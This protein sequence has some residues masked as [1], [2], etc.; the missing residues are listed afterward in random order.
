M[1]VFV[2]GAID[3]HDSA[4]PALPSYVSGRPIR[5]TLVPILNMPSVV[6][7]PASPGPG[8]LARVAAA[9]VALLQS[10]ERSSLRARSRLQHVRDLLQSQ[11]ERIEAVVS[12]GDEVG[13]GA[14]SR[15]FVGDMP[16]YNVGQV[17]VKV[18]KVSKAHAHNMKAFLT[19][20][21]IMMQVMHLAFLPLSFSP[22]P[23][24]LLSWLVGVV[25]AIALR[26]LRPPRNLPPD[27][28]SLSRHP[29]LDHP[30]ILPLLD[31]CVRAKGLERYIV[32]PFCEGG[33]LEFQLHDTESGLAN[34]RQRLKIAAGIAEGLRYLHS[35]RVFHRD[36]K[37]AN[38][39]LT[40]TL[41]PFLT[42]FGVSA[43]VILSEDEA[44][45]TSYETVSS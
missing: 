32:M 37:P 1:P 16:N 3:T 25:A 21:E 5:D 35:Q 15:V 13:V 26:A 9:A 8:D 17:V 40:S 28:L 12:A 42:D 43:R 23:L 27:P 20:V 38:V 18:L 33:S 19:E 2:G 24:P 36:L 39:V 34:G 31:T 29:Q 22:Y 44:E 7:L 4:Y 41:H 10:V 11:W 14:Y 6:R 45:K 30:N